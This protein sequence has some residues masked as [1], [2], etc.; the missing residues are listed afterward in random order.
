M[1]FNLSFLLNYSDKTAA[2]AFIG[3]NLKARGWGTL[4]ECEIECCNSTLCNVDRGKKIQLHCGK[5][6][7]KKGTNCQT[8]WGGECGQAVFV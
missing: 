4:K 8:Y 6:Q 1:E 7:T 2:C 5:Y 3:G